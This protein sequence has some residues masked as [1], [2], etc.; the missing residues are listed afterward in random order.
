M[1]LFKT[2]FLSNPDFTESQVPVLTVAFASLPTLPLSKV[3]GVRLGEDVHIQEEAGSTTALLAEVTFEG[4]SVQLAALE[5]PVPEDVL[6]RTLDLSPWDPDFQDWVRARQQ[7]HWLVRYGGVHTRGE[8]QYLALYRFLACLADLPVDQQ[9]LA[10]LNEPAYTA[11][12]FHFVQHVA[13]HPLTAREVP[14]A[15]FWTG[16]N[17]FDLETGMWLL[18]RGYRFFQQPELAYFPQ[19]GESLDHAYNLLHEVF[20][21]RHQMLLEGK[22]VL[23]GDILWLDPHGYYELL[24][25][26]E[27]VALTHMSHPIEIIRHVPEDAVASLMQTP[28][29]S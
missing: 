17:G 6:L 18:S 25:G 21:Y 5:S 29:N 26:A 24:S 12:P 2:F 23:P 27:I 22:E 13:S 8:E 20:L 9:P 15:E 19:S 7:A 14:P 28:T 11:H 16:C 3:L 4:H 1:S 10:L